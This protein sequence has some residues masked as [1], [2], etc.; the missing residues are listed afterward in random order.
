MDMFDSSSS[1]IGYLSAEDVAS[2]TSRDT[3]LPK[4]VILK[5]MDISKKINRLYEDYENNPSRFISKGEKLLEEIRDTGWNIHVTSCCGIY[6]ED[7]VTNEIFAVKT[8]VTNHL[9]KSVFLFKGETMDAF[10]SAI[11]NSLFESL[12]YNNV[13]KIDIERVKRNEKRP[14][15]YKHK[16]L[17][18][19]D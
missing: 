8:D 18:L 3:K 12:F 6:F 7:S 10:S 19:C 2:L 14:L 16:E 11:K 15:K 1:H 4:E 9:H 17:S 13:L 5:V